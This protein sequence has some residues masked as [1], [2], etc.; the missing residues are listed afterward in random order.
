MASVY[1]GFVV[2]GFLLFL[3][4][5]RLAEITKVLDSLIRTNERQNKTCDIH[6]TWIKRLQE[7][8]KEEGE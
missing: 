2:V 1:F 8:G 4:G 6:Q 5:T 3:I 7:Q